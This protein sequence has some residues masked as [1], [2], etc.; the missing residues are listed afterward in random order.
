MPLFQFNHRFR[1]I[2]GAKLA[3]WSEIHVARSKHASITSANKNLKRELVLMDI[4]PYMERNSLKCYSDL[5]LEM[6]R[7]E[8]VEE[9][10]CSIEVVDGGSGVVVL[11]WWFCCGGGSAGGGDNSFLLV[12]MENYNDPPVALTLRSKLSLI[13][14][15]KDDTEAVPFTYTIN[16]HEI[17]FEDEFGIP[18]VD[19]SNIIGQMLINKIHSEEFYSL[20]D[21]DVVAVCLLAVLHM[22][23]LGQEPKNN[24][25]NWWLSL[26]D[27]INMWEKY[28]WGSYIWPKL[29]RQ[30]KDANP[31]RWD[32]FYASLRDPIRRPAKYT[33][34]GFTWA[35]KTWILEAYKERALNYYTHVDRHPRAV[36]WVN[37]ETFYRSYLEAFF[38]GAEPIRRLRADAFEAK[39]EL[40]VLM[41]LQEAHDEEA[42]LEEQ[43]LSLMHRFADRFTNRRAEIN[44]LV[45]LPNHQLIEYGRYALGCMTGADMKKATYLKSVRDE[46]LRSMEEKRQLIKNYKEM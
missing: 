4:A 14:S 33:L 15:L 25:P 40:T 10:L 18:H 24:V 34:S 21:E 42:C 13:K 11:W 29:Y 28:P 36:A 1:S 46:L 41:A 22:V 20:R 39:A 45:S 35:F 30:L 43:I 12:N 9:E 5:T 27:D 19:G 26:V 6:T 8:E 44:R 38:E 17:Q 16:G 7:Q 2:G 32:R 23:L 3:C 37:A 31:K